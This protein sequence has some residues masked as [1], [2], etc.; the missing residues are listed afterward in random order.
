MAWQLFLKK[1]SAALY[2]IA[3][4]LIFSVKRGENSKSLQRFLFFPSLGRWAK[5]EKNDFYHEPLRNLYSG[6]DQLLEPMPRA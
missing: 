2:F 5:W 4:A 3:E 1:V 6:V